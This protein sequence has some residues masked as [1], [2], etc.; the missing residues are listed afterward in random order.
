MRRRDFSAGLVL[1]VAAGLARR[2]R[3][4]RQSA[5]ELRS[6]IAAFPPISSSRPEESSGYVS[7]SKSCAGSAM[8][9]DET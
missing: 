3:K 2:A 5:R 1:L 7:S 8:R 6:F 9:M 4:Y